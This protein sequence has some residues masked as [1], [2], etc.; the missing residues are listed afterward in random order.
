MIGLAFVRQFAAGQQIDLEVAD[1]ESSFR[2]STSATRRTAT[3][4]GPSGTATRTEM[5]R[6]SSRFP[7]GSIRYSIPS[8]SRSS[9]SRTSTEPSLSAVCRGSLVSIRTR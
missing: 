3:S 8:S 9:T 2:S 6:S 1:T 5:D 4:A 7:T